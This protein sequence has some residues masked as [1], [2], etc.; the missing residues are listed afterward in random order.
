MGNPMRFDRTNVR[1]VRSVWQYVN[2]RPL[3]LRRNGSQLK[4]AKWFDFSVRL[5]S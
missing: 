2:R 4:K 5:E 1:D 3:K